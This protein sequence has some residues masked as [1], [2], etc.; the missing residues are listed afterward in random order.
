MEENTVMDESTIMDK[1]T[2]DWYNEIGITR[3]VTNGRKR[4]RS[5]STVSQGVHTLLTPGCVC[6]RI[7]SPPTGAAQSKKHDEDDE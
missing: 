1:S 4:Q 5:H 7:A 6:C 2:N 3:T